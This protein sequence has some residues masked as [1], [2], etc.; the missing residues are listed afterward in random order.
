MPL[1][2]SSESVASNSAVEAHLVVGTRYAPP[3]RISNPDWM[4]LR[5]SSHATHTATTHRALA[6]HAYPPLSSQPFAG[7]RAIERGRRPS[8]ECTGAH[9]EQR[10]RSVEELVSPWWVQT[11][12]HYGTH[13]HLHCRQVERQRSTT[14]PQTHSRLVCSRRRAMGRRIAGHGRW[15]TFWVAVAALHSMVTNPRLGFGRH[16]PHRHRAY[17]AR[18]DHV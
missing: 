2:G 9:K 5:P 13:R 6:S 16:R 17:R 14:Q 3:R 1:T 7:A 4:G 12:A 18:T 8:D 15:W 11:T 10:L